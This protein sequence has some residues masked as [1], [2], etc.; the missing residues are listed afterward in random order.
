MP[1]IILD[2]DRDY[3]TVNHRDMPRRNSRSGRGTA[4]RWPL[5]LFDTLGTIYDYSPGAWSIPVAHKQEKKPHKMVFRCSDLLDHR[6]SS[7]SVSVFHKRVF[8]WH[9]RYWRPIHMALV[10]SQVECDSSL[11]FRENKISHWYQ[12]NT[13]IKSLKI[14]AIGTFVI[15]NAADIV[16]L[17]ED[18]NMKLPEKKRIQ[19]YLWPL[20]SI[21]L[22]VT[23]VFVAIP[24]G[25]LAL[26]STP[27]FAIYP[28]RHAHRYDFEATPH[29][30]RRLAQWREMYGNLSFRQRITRARKKRHRRTKR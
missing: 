17:G 11:Q 8:V 5:V 13:T 29:Q 15:D 22:C 21:V 25:I 30:K 4:H 3:R 14:H 19:W 7:N 20:V 2:I 28:E 24:L 1:F 26:F 9:R 6:S 10:I 23:F 12:H 16:M 27:Y 18:E